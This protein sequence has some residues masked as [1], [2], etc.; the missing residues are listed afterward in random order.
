MMAWFLRTPTWVSVL[1]AV[2]VGVGSAGQSHVNGALSVSLQSQ[3]HAAVIS[4]GGA[5]FVML[6]IAAARKSVRVGVGRVVSA[7]RSG[8]LPWWG[9]LGGVFGAQMVFAQ[10][11]LVP[12]VGVAVFMTSRVVGQLIGSLSIDHFG[13]IDVPVKRLTW[14]RA[15]G[16]LL[17]IGAVVLVA[18]GSE[19]DSL[20]IGYLGLGSF[21]G[22]LVAL[23]MG[24]TGTVRSHAQNSQSS[25][26]LNFFVGSLA[27]FAVAVSS[28]AFGWVEP[29]SL[30]AE[31]WMYLGGPLGAL[32][33]FL[34]AT[35]V[36][37]LGVM[38]LSLSIVGGQL[39]GALIF[40]AIVGQ[41][42]LVLVFGIALAFIGILVT[43]IGAKGIR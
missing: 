14:T 26:L 31:W 42:S 7:L 33:V 17:A 29:A 32:Y 41:L 5:L 38:L 43:N 2:F 25:T 23:Q 22:F 13:W 19:I 1:L 12:I 34:I 11:L 36:R 9:L 6:L 10:T 35:I 30:P 21:A 40:D 4:F 37:R 20:W 16:A 28:T 8:E 15:L 18:L 39:L 3:P 24:V 27:L